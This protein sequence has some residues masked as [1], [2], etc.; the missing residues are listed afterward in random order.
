[1]LPLKSS[2]LLGRLAVGVSLFGHG[3]VRLP[4]LEKFSQGMVVEFQ[5]SILP[6][7]LVLA[8]SYVLPF[9]EF[10]IGLLLILGLFTRQ[11]L[12]AGAVVMI[13]LIFGC[14]TVENWNPIALQLLHILFLLGLLAMV[15][16][17]DSYSLDEV[18]RRRRV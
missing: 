11:A 8:F 7:P 4:K 16:T 1:M 18:L 10:L 6:G 15:D 9:A 3:L 5:H 2:Y 14:T 17:Y 13:L 12:V